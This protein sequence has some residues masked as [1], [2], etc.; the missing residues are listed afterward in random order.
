[1]FLTD[2]KYR[3]ED[4]NSY[5]SRIQN[6]VENIQ[7]FTD[8]SNFAQLLFDLQKSYCL[9]DS[10][11]IQIH[12]NNDKIL[13]Y[14]LTKHKY[15]ILKPSNGYAADGVQIFSNHDPDVVSLIKQH[16]QNYRTYQTWIV[17]EYLYDPLLFRGRKFHLRMYVLVLHTSQFNRAYFYPEG[18]IYAARTKYGHP[19]DAMN[20]LKDKTRHITN[21]STGG[22]SFIFP[23][24]WPNAAEAENIVFEMAKMCKDVVGSALKNID[25][26]CAS[27]HANAICYDTLGLDV[28]IQKN[29]DIRILD[30]NSGVGFN[31]PS[32]QWRRKFFKNTMDLVLESNTKTIW[33]RL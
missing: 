20:H 8:K 33:I 14:A 2:G 32:N 17:Q 24:Q 25:L 18:F 15:V 6:K 4:P 27:N 7:V 3:R 21:I 9:P 1:M 13:Q 11:S 16:I 31:S 29:G 22:E 26:S 19:S 10:I 28:M 5:G 23:E 12:D 30:F